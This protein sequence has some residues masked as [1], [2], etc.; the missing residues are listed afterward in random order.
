MFIKLCDNLQEKFYTDFISFPIIPLGGDWDWALDNVPALSGKLA[1]ASQ[2]NPRS[3][4]KW[5]AGESRS[6]PLTAAA[7]TQSG[8]SAGEDSPAI[9]AGSNP[10]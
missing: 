3:V 4:H 6:R 9:Y 10:L 8:R 2:T 7:F 1:S 5:R